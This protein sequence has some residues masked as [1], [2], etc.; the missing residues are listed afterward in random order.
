MLGLQGFSTGRQHFHSMQ[1]HVTRLCP[2]PC[3][4]SLSQNEY[5]ALF[6][7]LIGEGPNPQVICFSETM[8]AVCLGAKI[9]ALC[10]LC[11]PP[12]PCLTYWGLT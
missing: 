4:L 11:L 3:P 7:A 1:Q 5:A 2:C 10:T 12:S 6:V 9:A 8:F